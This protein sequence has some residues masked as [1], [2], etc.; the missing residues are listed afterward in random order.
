MFNLE[1]YST[2]MWI[3]SI[4]YSSGRRRLYT[5]SSDAIGQMGVY[6]T[7]DQLIC[8]CP[9][10]FML[11]CMLLLKRDDGGEYISIK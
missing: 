1:A 3:D 10:V 5:V 4:V 9:A 8:I 6:S 11:I 7:V 2:V